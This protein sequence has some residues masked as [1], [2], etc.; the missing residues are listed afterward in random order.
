ME[1]WIKFAYIS[2]VKH[3]FKFA[4]LRQWSRKPYIYNYQ[5]ANMVINMMTE[6]VLR[7]FNSNSK[8]VIKKIDRYVIRL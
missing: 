8:E 2:G 3:N 5:M 1:D 4:E 6:K 7:N